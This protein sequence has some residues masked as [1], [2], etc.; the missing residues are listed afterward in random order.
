[1]SIAIAVLGCSVSSF[2]DVAGKD[3]SFSEVPVEEATNY[4]AED[5]EIV[6]RLHEPLLERLRA[7]DLMPLFESVEMPLVPVLAT[8]E[9]NGILLDSD[10]LRVQGDE[11]RRA[12]EI[13]ESDL[14]DI[15]GESFNPNSPKQ[16]AEILFYRLGLPVLSKTKT[17]PSTS[18][19]VLARLAELHPLPGKLM[20]HREL[21]KLLTTYIDQ[22]PKAVNPNTG[23]IHS[24]F[25]QTS[26]ATGRLSSSDP[27][28]QNIPTRTE[29]GGKI[30]GAFIASPGCVLIAADYSQIELRLL[31][32]FSE[33]ENLIEGF[34]SGIDLH[35]LTASH[36]FGLPESEVTDQLRD[37]AKRINFGILY[38][39]SPFG[40]G[41][42]LRIP[43]SEAKAYIDRF[44]SAYPRARE[45][46]DRLVETATKKGYAETLLGRRR[47]L[48]NLTSRNV[49][50]R[51]F[52]RRNA[53]NTP[54][55]GSAA[56][57]IKLAM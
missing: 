14:F 43:Q 9:S 45:T 2:S 48:P 19:Q 38:G 3:G 50:Q 5:A 7:Q 35:R 41:R 11:I 42:E 52:D 46:I 16:V 23:R 54:I 29:T 17:G 30:R 28:L 49:Q 39:I 4:A 34:N 57:L 32:H 13:L 15:A 40:L 8:M 10:V 31:A 33:D 44:F 36:V 6:Q 47:P 1:E 20:T 24:S 26:T 56:D 12:L 37:A 27:N 25:H 22:L 21:K 51:N 18:A 55:Q 53:V